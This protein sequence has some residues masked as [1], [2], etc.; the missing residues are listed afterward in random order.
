LS[1]FNISI[2]QMSVKELQILPTNLTPE[3]ILNPEGI[4]KIKGRWMNEN[5]AD[6]SK[7]ILDWF[8]TYICDPA[9]ITCADIYL[10]YFKGVNLM[11]FISLLKKITYIKLKDKKFV[12]NWYYEEGDEDILEQGEYI[13]S[14][15]DVPFNFIMIPE[16]IDD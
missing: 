16:S 9:E 5:I 11:I 6:F 1:I 12:I 4:I 15:L 3:I 8:D 14:F 2:S 10:E 7:P 13:S